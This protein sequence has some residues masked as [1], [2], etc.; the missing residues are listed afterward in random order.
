MGEIKH[1]EFAIQIVI[2]VF[3]AGK[4]VPV[5]VIILAQSHRV[6]TEKVKGRVLACPVV[7]PLSTHLEG[8]FGD[9][10]KNLHGRHELTRGVNRDLKTTGT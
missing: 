9:G 8:A 5:D 6:G 1:V 10:I 2:D 4:V 7:R 3:S